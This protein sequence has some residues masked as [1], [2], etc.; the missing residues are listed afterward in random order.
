M[1]RRSGTQVDAIDDDKHYIA[2]ALRWQPNAATDALG[3]LACL[4]QAETTVRGAS[5]H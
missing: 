3:D 1:L 5:Y 4:G 2:P